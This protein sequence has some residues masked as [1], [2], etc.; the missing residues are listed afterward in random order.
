[1]YENIMLK[2]L[3]ESDMRL[4][5]WDNVLKYNSKKLIEIKLEFWDNIQ[6]SNA[7]KL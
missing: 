7:K 1:M 5:F 3:M 6:K 2:K 4:G